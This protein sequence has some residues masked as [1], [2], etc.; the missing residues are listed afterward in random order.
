M[1]EK[2]PRG[3][4]RA[5]QPSLFPAFYHIVCRRLEK[6]IHVTTDG[7]SPIGTRV[8][9]DDTGGPYRQWFLQGSSVSGALFIRSNQFYKGDYKQQ[10]C[11][12]DPYPQDPKNPLTT[13]RHLNLDVLNGD[14]SAGALIVVA[15]QH[16]AQKWI[17]QSTGKAGFYLLQSALSGFYLRARDKNA[18]G[19]FLITQDDRSLAD[20]WYFE[21]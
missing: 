21:S 6:L 4:T 15:Q 14:T 3:L 5:D 10:P 12:D 13:F 16:C 11:S 1:P 2:T 7:G 9:M 17:L 20:E 8:S 19:L 18:E